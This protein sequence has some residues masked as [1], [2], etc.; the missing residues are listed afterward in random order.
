MEGQDWLNF[1]R[2]T[3]IQ[4]VW[5]GPLQVQQVVEGGLLELSGFDSLRVV[6][7]TS[8]GG[9]SLFCSV[10]F[11]TT[12]SGSA[13]WHWI[14]GY[15]GLKLQLKHNGE[16]ASFRSVFL[17]NYLLR[18]RFMLLVSPGKSVL[19]CPSFTKLLVQ[20]ALHG[21]GVTVEAECSDPSCTKLLAQGALHGAGV[22]GESALFL[23]ALRKTTC[24][25]S[26]AWHWC[27][28]AMF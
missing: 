20:G 9:S 18:E 4:R 10:L 13:I 27:L 24:S 1:E 8:N 14:P 6:V 22:P 2:V 28:C 25:G 15:G 23:F 5:F 12:C 7:D 19:F 17:Q 16:G 21:A 11:K 3:E 26:A